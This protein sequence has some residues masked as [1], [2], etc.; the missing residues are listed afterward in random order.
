MG[1]SILDILSHELAD[2]RVQPIDLH[3]TPAR[4]AGL[5]AHC[6]NVSMLSAVSAGLKGETRMKKL[7]GF[8]ALAASCFAVAAPAAVAADP[9]PGAA[10]E[11]AAPVA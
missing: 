8:A 3:A 5:H 4:S 1:F 7:I 11:S 2:G 9:V 10:P 6:W